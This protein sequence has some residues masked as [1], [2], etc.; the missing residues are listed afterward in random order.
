VPPPPAAH[1]PDADNPGTGGHGEAALVPRRPRLAL[2]VASAL[3][4][5]ALT[6]R[7]VS[8]DSRHAISMLF[9]LP[10]ALLAVTRGRRAGILGGLVAVAMVAIGASVTQTHLTA[11]GWTSRAVPLLLVSTLLREGRPRPE[12]V[13]ASGARP[14]RVCC[15]PL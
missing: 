8:G 9:V 15:W 12:T 11:L 2:S 4:A 5:L 3:F 6:L 13:H 1:W 10:V 14:A 7:L